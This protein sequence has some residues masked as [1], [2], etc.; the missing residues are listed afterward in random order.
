MLPN[1][2]FEERQLKFLEMPFNIARTAINCNTLIKKVYKNNL[3]EG[4]SGLSNIGVVMHKIL[5]IFY[6][7]L[8]STPPLTPILTEA[9]QSMLLLKNQKW[10]C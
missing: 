5:R 3:Q 2:I 9:T 6:G 4:K 1:R 7:M 8:K 10:L